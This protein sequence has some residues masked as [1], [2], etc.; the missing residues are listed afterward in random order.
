MAA[1]LNNNIFLVNAPAGSGKTTAIRGMVE[2]HLRESPKDNILCITFTNRAAEELGRNID[3]SNVFF[4][5]IHSYINSFLKSFFSHKEILDLYWEIYGAE[6]KKRIENIDQ[7]PY[8]CESN[9]RYVEKNGELSLEALKSRIKAISY[10]EAPFNSLYT[11]GIGHD[12]LISF[13]RIVTERFPIVRKKISGKFQ[14]VFIDEYQDT[15]ADVLRIFYNAMRDENGK[16]YLLGDRMQQ[17]YDSYDGTFEREFSLMN[18]SRRLETN[19]RATPKLVSILN[20]IYNDENYKQYAYEGNK[21]EKMDY[22]PEVIVSSN[23]NAAIQDKC[24]KY[25]KALV[26]YLLNSTRFSEIGARNLYDA[27]SKIEEYK[28]GGKYS[29]VDVLTTNDETNPDHLFFVLFLLSAIDDLY[30]G[31]KFGKLLRYVKK[32]RKVFDVTK[33]TITRHEDKERVNSVFAQITDIYHGDSSI[34]DA[35]VNISEVEVIDK[36]RLDSILQNPKYAGV[37]EVS[38][39]EFRALCTYL[40]TQNISTQHGVKGESHDTVI[41]VAEDSTQLNVKMNDFFK[42]WS[43]HDIKLQVLEDLNFSYAAMI[44]RVE[45]I[46]GNKISADIF[47]QKHELLENVLCDFASHNSSN[48]LFTTLCQEDWNIF[49]SKPNATNFNKCIKKTRVKS[50]LTAYKLFYVG[51]SRARKN[52]SIIVDKNEVEPFLDTLKSKLELVGFNVIIQ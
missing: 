49:S 16:L 24:E 30:Q 5:T 52:L 36:E 29:I 32:N 1:E 10:T 23:V 51:C 46:A 25:P 17:I 11:G 19:Y 41:F 42:I 9:Q 27:V 44:K 12:D 37:L 7:T 3:S 39:T 20:A 34:R 2:K 45:E 26:L 6:I 43:T 14:I 31:R 4:G 8:I 21:D 15:N 13:T 35:I 22:M 18:T 38:L 28:F 33:C 48:E 40:H 47:N 50:I